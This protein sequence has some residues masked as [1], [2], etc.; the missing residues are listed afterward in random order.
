MANKLGNRCVLMLFIVS[1][2]ILTMQFLMADLEGGRKGVITL[3]APNFVSQEYGDPRFDIPT[4]EARAKEICNAAATH[5]QLASKTLLGASFSPLS[6]PFHKIVKSADVCRQ[7]PAMV[8]FLEAL[9]RLHRSYPHDER[10]WDQWWNAFQDCVKDTVIARMYQFGGI[11]LS[12][13]LYVAGG[14]GRYVSR[15]SIGHDPREDFFPQELVHT[16]AKK[17]C[18]NFT[19]L[20][21]S[22]CDYDIYAASRN[23]VVRRTALRLFL[24]D[25]PNFFFLH[26]SPSMVMPGNIGASVLGD[27]DPFYPDRRE[28][29]L[30]FTL[31]P[32]MI[33]IPHF[34]ENVKT[35]ERIMEDSWP[36]R[37]YGSRRHQVVWR[38]SSTGEQVPYSRS[39]RS[40]VVAQFVD[41]SGSSVPWA[42]VAFSA[43]LCQGV[44]RREV[45]RVAHRMN[46]DSLMHYQVHL[47]IDG[48]TNS[49][50]GLRWRLIFGMVVVKARSSNGY[51]QW[52]Y[53][54]LQ[55]GVNI[56]E[57]PV[58][59]VGE[60]ARAVLNDVDRGTNIASKA[61][62]FGDLYLS[63]P[64]MERAVRNAVR[65]AWRVGYDDRTKW[66]ISP[67]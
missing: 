45:P 43:P 21:L 31:F 25:F 34:P 46:A 51:T 35:L 49:W 47:D 38:G 8:R 20:F 13:Q 62:E 37:P 66:C 23:D 39:D 65:N 10:C 60:A 5:I 32:R 15:Y 61:K 50:D 64:A 4:D 22:Y 30:Y 28:K 7:Y 18:Q 9:R 56:I 19:I 24:A 6:P 58:D 1:C 17:E 44:T 2:A 63:F 3:H 41:A 26:Y 48:N 12:G 52:Y 67:C 53:P 42:D 33:P 55:N 16:S 40:R 57:V 29:G 59:E 54:R 36:P 14:F 27:R 11:E